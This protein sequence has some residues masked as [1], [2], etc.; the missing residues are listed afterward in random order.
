MICFLGIL[1]CL[2]TS[3]TVNSQPLRSVPSYRYEQQQQQQP[4][5]SYQQYGQEY[6]TPE[7]WGRRQQQI[8][9]QQQQQIIPQKQ[10]QIMPQQQQ[11]PI[12][13]NNIINKRQQPEGGL[14]G[15]R[16][17]SY[18]NSFGKRDNN[19]EQQRFSTDIAI[20]ANEKEIVIR[21]LVQLRAEVD[22]ILSQHFN[23]IPVKQTTKRQVLESAGLWG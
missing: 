1:L 10:Q 11:Q 19:I 16:G 22:E 20:A 13:H 5:K 6:G 4:F 21:K 12:E 23:V 9:P 3:S 2:T 15:K 14:W 8:I 7:L 17:N 18:E